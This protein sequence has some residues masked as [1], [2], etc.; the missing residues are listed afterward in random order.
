MSILK[1]EH[2][3]YFLIAS[4]P[5]LVIDEGLQNMLNHAELGKL[6]STGLSTAFII[7]SKV[8]DQLTESGSLEYSDSGASA[9]R[10]KN[11]EAYLGHEI[12]RAR[13]YQKF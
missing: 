6:L 8:D 13:T 9:N 5:I 12:C 7:F 3:T 1:L 2:S 4:D 10:P 11:D